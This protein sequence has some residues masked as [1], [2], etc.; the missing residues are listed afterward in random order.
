MRRSEIAILAP[1]TVCGWRS[2]PNRG[3]QP[4]QRP[5]ESARGRGR[6]RPDHQQPRRWVMTRPRFHTGRAPNAGAV[7][8]NRQGLA[9]SARRERV[10]TT[11]AACAGCTG[12]SFDQTACPPDKTSPYLVLGLPPNVGR[13]W[14]AFRVGKIYI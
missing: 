10:F 12:V 8:V 13:I 6:P 7:G 14:R 2:P 9:V 1:L 11:P 4:Q 3:R 5:P